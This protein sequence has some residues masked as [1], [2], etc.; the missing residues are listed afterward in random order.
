MIIEIL[1]TQI[2]IQNTDS[3]EDEVEYEPQGITLLNANYNNHESLFRIST[4]RTQ[5]SAYYNI[6]HA[7]YKGFIMPFFSLI[8]YY[9]VC[10]KLLKL[11]S[12]Q[13]EISGLP[14]IIMPSTFLTFDLL[15]QKVW[16]GS[17]VLC[18]YLLDNPSI[19]RGH[20]VMIYLQNIEILK[21]S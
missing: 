18:E 13:T 15:G 6:V 17:A 20:S 7:T 12:N 21:T 2:M 19:V 3:D 9:S 4:T 1:E 5:V 16:C 8:A 11:H 14:S 10:V